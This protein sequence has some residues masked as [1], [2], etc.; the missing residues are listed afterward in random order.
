[1]GS[2]GSEPAY[3]SCCLTPDREY[4]LTAVCLEMLVKLHSCRGKVLKKLFSSCVDNFK[5]LMA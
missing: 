1:M 3:S 5:I 2:G 4:G